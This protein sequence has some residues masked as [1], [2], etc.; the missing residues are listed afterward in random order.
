MVWGCFAA[1]EPRRLAV[2]DA[3]H[4]FFFL[5]ENAEGDLRPSTQFLNLKNKFTYERL[6][7]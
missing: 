4:E 3:N 1:S 7:K 2:I 5:S 6:K